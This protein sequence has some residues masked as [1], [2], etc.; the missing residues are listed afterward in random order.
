M[1]LPHIGH[2]LHSLWVSSEIHIIFRLPPHAPIFM[3]SYM[4]FKRRVHST[5]VANSLNGKK[6]GVQCFE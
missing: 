4:D 1:F 3:Y 5:E 2:V 6:P